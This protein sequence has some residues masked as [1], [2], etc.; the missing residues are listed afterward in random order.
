MF[1]FGPGN[2]PGLSRNGPQVYVKWLATFEFHASCITVHIEDRNLFSKKTSTHVCVVM[3]CHKGELACA[4]P[5]FHIKN[6]IIV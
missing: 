1:D 5:W 4:W 2:L 3:S 6:L